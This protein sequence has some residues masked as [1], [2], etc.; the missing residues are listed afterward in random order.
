MVKN[1][2][3]T[4]GGTRDA[5]LIP[6][7]GISP[8][9]RT[10]NQFQYSCLENSM[11]KRAWQALVCGVTKSQTWRSVRARM[12]SC[13]SVSVS[14]PYCSPYYWLGGGSHTS[15]TGGEIEAQRCMR[16]RSGQP[17]DAGLHL[18]SSGSKLVPPFCFLHS[19]GHLLYRH[20]CYWYLLLSSHTDPTKSDPQK[21]TTGLQAVTHS[22]EN[23]ETRKIFCFSPPS[24]KNSCGTSPQGPIV[25]LWRRIPAW[26]SILCDC[27]MSL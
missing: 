9:V 13:R 14:T 15:S 20:L 2:P 19:E 27:D 24:W 6:G 25:E 11:G 16:W 26:N 22:A 17:A 7:S 5:G 8:G 21:C 18:T 12:H 23:R 4:A 1:L 3:A 10:S